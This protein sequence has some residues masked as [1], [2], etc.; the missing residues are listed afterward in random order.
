MTNKPK[1]DGTAW[2]TTVKEYLQSVGLQPKR[3]GSAEAGEGDIHAG[4]WTL[5]CKAE[6]RIDLPGYLAQVAAAVTRRGTPR[7]FSAVWVKNRRHGVKDAYVVMSGENYRSLMVFTESMN[8]MLA[9]M[10]TAILAYEQE[11]KNG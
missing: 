2:E 5:E 9:E 7:W 10:A 1:A 6:A 8:S 4:L 11:A 3:T